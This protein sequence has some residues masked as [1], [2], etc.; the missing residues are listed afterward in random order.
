[1]PQKTGEFGALLC[2]L[3][4][5]RKCERTL[6]DTMQEFN[7]YRPNMLCK[8]RYMLKALNLPLS[9]PFSQY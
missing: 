6:P 7:K 8:R 3:F 9:P 4:D 5:V 2:P 1:M